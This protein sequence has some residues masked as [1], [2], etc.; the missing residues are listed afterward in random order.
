[1]KLVK[2][3]TC[4]EEFK[5]SELRF[6]NNE[7]HYCCRECCDIGRRKKILTTCS[8]CHKEIMKAPSQIRETNFCC[9][10]CYTEYRKR[11]ELNYNAVCENCKKQLKKNTHHL[12]LYKHHFCS[13]ECFLENN[14]KKKLKTKCKF[15]KKTLYIEQSRI[16]EGRDY[17]CDS[18]CSKKYRAKLKEKHMKKTQT[19]VRTYQRAYY[20][21][22]PEIKE[23]RKYTYKT[24]EFRRKSVERTAKYKEANI[25]LLKE[26]NLITN[27]IVCG[28]SRENFVA[29]DFHH[30]NASTKKYNISM[31]FRNMPN[32]LKHKKYVDELK[33]CVCLCSNCHRLLH[34]DDQKI[35]EKYNEALKLR[36]ENNETITTASS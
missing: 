2:C 34:H 6:K 21:A 11:N 25:K 5:T 26:N 10:E 17:F 1:M 4:G 31:K 15:C 16:K 7:H 8:Y 19:R 28:Y 23:K 18:D 3:E 22:H 33:K 35:I 12:K 30:I 32:I 9:F 20:H 36:E 13:Y 27:C 29:I 14:K 24:S